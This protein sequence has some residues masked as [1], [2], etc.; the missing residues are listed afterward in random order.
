MRHLLLICISLLFCI[1]SLAEE[2][3]VELC[4]N[5]PEDRAKDYRSITLEPTA[6]IDGNTIR[7]YTNV[8]ITD[9]QMSIKDSMGNIIYTYNGTTPSRYHTFEIYDLPESDY[10]LEV[11]IGKESYYGTFSYQ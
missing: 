9:L 3:V 8:T 1:N 5:Y 11:K 4:R 2:V 6:T 10:I 7:I